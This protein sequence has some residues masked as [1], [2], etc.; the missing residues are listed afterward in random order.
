V[1]RLR[2]P[3]SKDF[4]GIIASTDLHGAHRHNAYF[5]GRRHGTRRHGPAEP[6]FPREPRMSDVRSSVTPTLLVDAALSPRPIAPFRWH[7]AD[8]MYPLV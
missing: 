5:D 8:D 7:Y 3:E 4:D 6:R 2:A 1:R